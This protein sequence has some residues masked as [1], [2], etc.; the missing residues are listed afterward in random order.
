[1]FQVFFMSSNV[2]IVNESLSSLQKSNSHLV[3]GSIVN[4]RVIS[5]KGDDSYVLSLCGKKIEVQSNILLKE[6]TPFRARL[7]VRQNTVFI[8]LISDFK[9]KNSQS[10]QILKFNSNE[11]NYSSL[12]QDLGLPLVPESFKLVQ[13]ALSMGIKLE[14]PKL[15][16]ALLA[17]DDGN[18]KSLEKSQTALLLTEKGIDFSDKTVEKIQQS[19][20]GQ[21]KDDEKDQ[22]T[23]ENK[24]T[25]IKKTEKE[26]IKNYLEQADDA[27]KNA[28][29]GLLTL[30]NSIKA[31][32]TDKLHWIVLPFEWDYRKFSGVIRVLYSED[33]KNFKKLVV[34]CDNSVKFY[35]FVLYF[36]KGRVSRVKVAAKDDFSQTSKEFLHAK[37]EEL[38]GEADFEVVEFEK[39]EGFTT[40]EDIFTFFRGEA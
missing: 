23:L 14:S 10:A 5:A 25:K 22:K 36:G 6:G 30:F 21:K 7:E 35:S 20:Y 39:L 2:R 32:D 37:F 27:S 11:K 26:D 16:K 24:K 19:F 28:Q 13:F 15:R 40:D 33:E 4:G 12:L 34:N 18:E 38:F 17:G 31:K 1:M 29:I 9:D 8:K 3:N